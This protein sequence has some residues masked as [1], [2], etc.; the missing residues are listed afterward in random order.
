MKTTPALERFKVFNQVGAIRNGKGTGGPFWADF[1]GELEKLPDK[2]IAQI[3]Q[4]LKSIGVNAIV[5]GHSIKK[6]P[7]MSERFNKYGIKLIAADV[8]MSNYYT[9][10]ESG[11]GGVKIDIRGNIRAQSKEGVHNIYDALK[12]QKGD[13]VQI[14]RNRKL[15]KDWQITNI[16]GDEVLLARQVYNGIE[17][18]KVNIDYLNKLNPKGGRKEK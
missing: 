10:G 7:T 16:D 8:G 3:A 2:D 12:I 4:N 6:T 15:E 11:R 1:D 14:Y 9:K 13:F 17:R 5:V 18:V